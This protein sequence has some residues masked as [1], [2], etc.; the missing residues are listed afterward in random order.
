MRAPEEL[1][2]NGDVR[3]F[4]K[5]LEYKHG[6]DA[7]IDEFDSE[8]K[9][10]QHINL[11]IAWAAEE[12]WKERYQVVSLLHHDNLHLRRF[13]GVTHEFMHQTGDHAFYA[14]ILR[15]LVRYLNH[16]LQEQD[17]QA[18]LYGAEE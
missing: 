13:H 2:E 3:P 18:D 17:I 9:K 4:S 7:L 15:D 12:R 8:V 10:P 5:T 16:P 1:F 11:V 6:L 14:V